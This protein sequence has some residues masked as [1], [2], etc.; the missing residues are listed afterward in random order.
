MSYT[1]LDVASTLCQIKDAGL[2]SA[3]QQLQCYSRTLNYDNPKHRG[4]Y[5][6]S[7]DGN[8]GAGK[9]TLIDNLQ[10]IYDIGTADEKRAVFGKFASEKILF[11]KEPVALWTSIRDPNTGESILEMF[12][13][14]PNKYSFAFQVMVYNTHLDAFRRIIREN[15]DSPLL[16]CERSIDAGRHIFTNM[17]HDDGMID[18]VSFQVYNQLYDNTSSEIVIDAIMHLDV[19]PEVCLQH[20]EKRARE[21]ESNISLEYLKKCDKYYKKWLL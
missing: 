14:D 13:K 5:I 1:N 4:P 6:I 20:V 17:L 10:N 15:P 19:S 18:D 16:F 2:I 7:I 8:I 21:G 11:M 3:N 9:S 12:Y